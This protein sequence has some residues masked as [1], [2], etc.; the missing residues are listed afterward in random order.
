MWFRGRGA[1]VRGLRGLG[2]G[3]VRHP[4]RL[5]GEAAAEVPARVGAEVADHQHHVI[6]ERRPAYG[7][8]RASA[9]LAAGPGSG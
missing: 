2:A 8:R 9:K 5:F 7:G 1:S 4:R 6:R 3:E